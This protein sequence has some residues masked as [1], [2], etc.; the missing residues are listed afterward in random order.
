V[1]GE[2]ADATTELINGASVVAVF[3]LRRHDASHSK[4]QSTTHPAA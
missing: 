2:S 3:R 1:H 4:S